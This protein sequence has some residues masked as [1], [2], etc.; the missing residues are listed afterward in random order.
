V[1]SRHESSALK[2]LIAKSGGRVIFVALETTSEESIEK[3]ASEVERMLE[4]K[5]LDVL[6]NNAGIFKW[7]PAGGITKMFEP[8]SPVRASLCKVY[9]TIWRIDLQE[10]LA[11][12][13][14]GVQLV[15]AAFMP[16]LEQGTLKKIANM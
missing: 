3:A 2:D 5:G 11:T 14:V 4:G 13:V 9:L 16:L 15:T 1:S 7:T 10:H 6:I 12:N 8:T